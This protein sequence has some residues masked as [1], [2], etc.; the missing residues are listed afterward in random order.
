M[1]ILYFCLAITD[2]GYKGEPSKVPVARE[3][4]PSE[5]VKFMMRAK[6]RG[7][8]FDKRLKNFKTLYCIVM[9]WIGTVEWL[10]LL[11]CSVQHREWKSSDFFVSW[12]RWQLLGFQC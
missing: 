3:G 7:E 2:S 11:L 1:P 8:I 4:H 12:W 10:G 6:A 5:L 9:V